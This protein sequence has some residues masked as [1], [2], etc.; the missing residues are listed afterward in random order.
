M[1]IER[2]F[3]IAARPDLPVKESLRVEQSYLSITPEVRIRRYCRGTETNYDL[4][5]KSEG[6]LS[7]QEV[8]KPLTAEEYEALLGMADREPIVKDYTAYALGPYTLEYSEVDGDKACGFRYAEVEFP[9]EAAAAAFSPPDFLGQEMT[10]VS[11][12]KMKR[13]W[14]QDRSR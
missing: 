11:G 10:Y 2:K 9:T 3:R 1:E 7:R 12:F 13:Y 6:T 14:L 5:I 8:I 4:T